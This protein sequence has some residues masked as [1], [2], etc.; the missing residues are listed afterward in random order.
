[1]KVGYLGPKNSFTHQAA[2]SCFP[3]NQLTSY[4]T[5]AACIHSV[6]QEEITYGVIP[7]ENSLE[8]SVNDSIDRLFHLGDLVVL[9]EIVLPIKQQLLVANQT[10]QIEKI[11]SHPQALAQ[12][13]QFLYEYY[14]T[15]PI[16]AVSSTTYAA[17]FVA[18]HPDLGLAAI[19]SKKAATE[20]GL[21]ILSADIQDNLFNQT[22]FWIISRKNQ[23]LPM[24]LGHLK[25]AT[26]FIT[27]ANNQAGSL[28]KILECFAK[29][30]IDLS[31]IESRPLKTS[32]GEY[33]FVL[34]LLYD[35]NETLILEAIEAVETIGGSVNYLGLYPLKTVLEEEL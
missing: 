27:L 24:A 1:M 32:L 12:S 25:K 6:Y 23:L 29:R 8:G 35:E 22:R 10:T 4:Q 28:H 11:L 30:A 13:Q 18:Q 31:K 14:P 33:F 19:A 5:I 20:Y 2:K 3:E 34:D 9:G 17:E 21:N 7:I 26:L 15:V 16:E